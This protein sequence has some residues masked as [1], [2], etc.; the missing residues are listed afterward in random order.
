MTYTVGKASNINKDFMFSVI[1]FLYQQNVKIMVGNWSILSLLLSD[2][3]KVI[4]SEW[5]IVLEIIVSRD[6]LL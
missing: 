2:V 6:Q 3:Y 5:S 4:T 1:H